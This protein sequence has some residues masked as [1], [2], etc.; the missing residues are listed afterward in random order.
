[1]HIYLRKYFENKNTKMFYCMTDALLKMIHGN[2]ELLEN[3]QFDE[4]VL[5]F[6]ANE[7][8]ESKKHVS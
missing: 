3:L 5:Q 6:V 1:M 2:K 7:I 4:S 8:E